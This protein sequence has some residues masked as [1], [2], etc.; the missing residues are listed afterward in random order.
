ML[1]IFLDIESTGLDFTRHHVV[2]IALKVVDLTTGEIVSSYESIVKQ[3]L[4]AW[5]KRDPLS[6]EINGFTFEKLLVGKEP[7]VVGEEI[8]NL[9]NGL[10]IK[11][12]EAV[13]ICQNPSFDRSFFSQLICPYTQE[14]YKWPYHWLD[15]ASMYL[16][17][18]ARKSLEE[19]DE[20]PKTISLSKND[21]AMS[22]GLPKEGIPHTAMNGV[23]HLIKCFEAV[24]GLKIKLVV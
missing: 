11:R 3:P 23:N 5:K 2:E 15:L 20:F 6:V 17:S 4:S 9:L 18:I 21:I 14:L 22:Y 10:K 1:G 7:K 16:A 8:V 13:F 12:G 19:G 24:V